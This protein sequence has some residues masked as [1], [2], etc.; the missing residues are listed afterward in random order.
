MI[1]GGPVFLFDVESKKTRRLGFFTTRW[2]QAAT[3]NE[4]SEIAQRLVLAE[5]AEKGTRNPP[6]Q[7]VETKIEEVVPLSWAES[8]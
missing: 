5:L 7:P 3:S 6:D 1:E 4:A 8:L 2:V